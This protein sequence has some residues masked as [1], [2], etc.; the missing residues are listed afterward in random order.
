[1]H[2]SFLPYLVCPK[3]GSDLVVSS[4]SVINNDIVIEGRLLGD[5]HSYP[6]KG[7]IPRFVEYKSDRYADSFGRQWSRWSR[8]QFD[9]QNENGPMEGHTSAMYQRIIGS[10]SLGNLTGKTV[11]DVGVGAGRFADVAIR[12]G[13]RVIGV[14]LSSAVEVARSNLP[15]HKNVLICQADALQLPIRSNSLGGAYSIGV[16]HHTP[17]PSKGLDEIMRVLEPGAWGAVAVYQKGGYYDSIRVRIWRRIFSVCGT[18]LPVDTLPL[19]YSKFVCRYLYSPS[20]VPVFGLVIRALFP[21][22][23][24]PDERWRVLDTFDSL[25]P[26]YQ[27]AHTAEEVR[28]WFVAAKAQNVTQSDWGTSTWRGQKE[29]LLNG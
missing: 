15:N 6:I 17:S 19:A 10:E 9:D 22:V 2:L 24:L 8:V 18:F 26:T 25:T 7:G 16:L 20:K 23:R 21:S 29:A 5:Q 28:D 11:L 14:D 12:H 13:A 27:S 4:D 1:M 3:T